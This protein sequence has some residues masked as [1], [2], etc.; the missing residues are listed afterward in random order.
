MPDN[1]TVNFGF[2]ETDVP[3]V[4]EPLEAD[5]ITLMIF[6]LIVA[7]LGFVAILAYANIKKDRDEIPE[8]R[9]EKIK[10]QQKEPWKAGTFK[11]E[12]YG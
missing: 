2:Y 12:G 9:R 4:P 7:V 3:I 6:V 10:K 11:D 8:E 1:K 5:F